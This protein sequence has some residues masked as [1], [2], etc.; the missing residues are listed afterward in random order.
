MMD[1]LCECVNVW[2]R[3]NEYMKKL[4]FK[5]MNQ[6]IK[7]IINAWLMSKWMNSSF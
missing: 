1:D 6:S 2:M 3:D 5:C 7:R 4:I